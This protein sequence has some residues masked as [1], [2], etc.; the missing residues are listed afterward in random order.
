LQ[1]GIGFY[2]VQFG[3]E[4]EGGIGEGRGFAECGFQRCTVGARTLLFKNA[5]QGWL[6]VDRRSEREQ[7]DELNYF[8]HRRIAAR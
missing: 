3:D 1:D 4:V 6:G 8:L 5:E 7:Y 2:L